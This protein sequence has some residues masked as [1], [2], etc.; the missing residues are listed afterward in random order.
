MHCLTKR[1]TLHPRASACGTRLNGPF[2]RT[3]QA[4]ELAVL[5]L[6]VRLVLSVLRSSYG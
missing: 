2:C 5:S 1:D 4:A 3:K 6:F